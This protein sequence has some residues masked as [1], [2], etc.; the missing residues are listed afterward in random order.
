MNLSPHSQL[1]LTVWLSPLGYEFLESRA[2]ILLSP[3]SL[4]CHIVF[5][6]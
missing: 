5:I 4:G 2:Y 1:V 6:Q 3:A